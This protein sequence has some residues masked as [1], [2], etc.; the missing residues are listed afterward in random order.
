[1]NRKH[2]GNKNASGCDKYVHY[3]FRRVN[4]SGAPTGVPR[5]YEG[6]INVTFTELHGIYGGALHH[7]VHSRRIYL[8]LCKIC[9]KETPMAE[10]AKEKPDEK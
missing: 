4:T 3:C 2:T 10:T 6:E 9:K 1:M 5:T 8:S 7:P